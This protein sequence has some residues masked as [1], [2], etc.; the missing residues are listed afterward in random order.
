[1]TSVLAGVLR[2]DALATVVLVRGDVELS[3][4]PLRCAGPTDLST[5]DVVARVALAARRLGCAIRLHDPDPDLVGLLALVGLA[6]VAG[7]PGQV[8]GE[9]EHREELGPEEVVVPDDP[10]P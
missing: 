1:V 4:W 3:R 2:R 7:L 9:P 5:V 8:V 6:E 10:V